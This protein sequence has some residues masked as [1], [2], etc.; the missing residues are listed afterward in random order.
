MIQQRILP[1]ENRAQALL[2]PGATAMG[3]SVVP[4]DIKDIELISVGLHPISCGGSNPSPRPP[5]APQHRIPTEG[6]LNIAQ[7]WNCPTLTKET[8]PCFVVVQYY[9]EKKKKTS[10]K[11]Y[12]SV[13]L[14]KRDESKGWKFRMGD[15]RSTIS[16]AELTSIISSPAANTTWRKK[17]LYIE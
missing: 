10:I 2:F 15:G 4:K 11:M 3:S 12:L 9:G 5:P 8:W 13:G 7:T 16:H 17:K 1:F 6:A 14:G